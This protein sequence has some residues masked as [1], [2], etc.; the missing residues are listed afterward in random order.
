[1]KKVNIFII[2]LWVIV[3]F[4]LFMFAHA[5]KNEYELDKY[6]K[7]QTTYEQ[8]AK[9]TKEAIVKKSSENHLENENKK[10]DYLNSVI[11]SPKSTI[12]DYSEASIVLAELLYSDKFINLQKEFDAKNLFEVDDKKLSSNQKK[13]KELLVL[14]G[15]LE[16]YYQKE[17]NKFVSSNIKQN[18]LNLNNVNTILVK[19][20]YDDKDK[21]T[22]LFEDEIEKH[23]MNI[24]LISPESFE[25]VSQAFQNKKPITKDDYYLIKRLNS[26]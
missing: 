18:I 7:Q 16:E 8:I 13:Y 2:T 25:Y 1:M 14:N 9:S 21:F 3:L 17:L 22:K 11:N 4:E 5:F 10:F 12:A 19:Y 15:K 24:F 20:Y 23:N 6:F 26:K